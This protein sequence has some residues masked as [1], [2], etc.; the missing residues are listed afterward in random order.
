MTSDA[1]PDCPIELAH[2]LGR[3]G[4]SPVYSIVA[5]QPSR[6]VDAGASPCWSRER[7]GVPI[8]AVLV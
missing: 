8:V 5:V 7:Q 2:R 4:S 1:T 6:V 3:R